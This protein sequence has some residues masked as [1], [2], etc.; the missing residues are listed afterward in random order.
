MGR[1]ATSGTADEHIIQALSWGREQDDPDAI[2]TVGPLSALSRRPAA[3]G[4]KG[5][6]SK[7]ALAEGL[8]SAPGRT[9]RVRLPPGHRNR[10]EMLFGP[11]CFGSSA[12]PLLLFRCFLAFIGR[13]LE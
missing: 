10:R 5:R 4:R 3:P 9:N 13:C 1:P 12:V 2:G 7:P 6:G 11:K 8:T